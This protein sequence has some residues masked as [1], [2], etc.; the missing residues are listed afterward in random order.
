VDFARVR[1]SAQRSGGMQ[2]LGPPPFE[3]MQSTTAAAPG[4]AAL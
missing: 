2:V 1:E 4:L 3:T